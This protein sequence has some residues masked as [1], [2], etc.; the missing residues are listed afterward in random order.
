VHI[1]FCVHK[2]HYC[3]FNSHE[4]AKPD[5][6]AYQQ[7]LT[8]EL[9]CWTTKPA[10]AGRRL[11]TI[12]FGGGTPSLA[13]PSL[14][15]AV[16]DT[17]R[18]CC[19]IED[20]AEISLEANPG[21]VDSDNFRAYRQAGINRLSIGVQS[22]DANELHWLERIHGRD[23]AI[24]AY[25][26]AR[27][28]G[29][30]NINLDLMYGLPGQRL[31]DWLDTL[32]TAIELTPEHLSCYQLTVEPHTKLAAAHARKPYALP[33][34]D[35]ALSMFFETRKQLSAAGYQAYEISNFAKAEKKCRHNDG[36]W[37][38]HDYIG[39]GAGASGKWDH[40]G[41]HLRDKTDGG[42]TRYS[43]FRSPERYSETALAHGAAI[44]TQ[45]SLDRNQAAA[46]ACW[47]GLR[48]SDGINRQ[49]FHNRFNFDVWEH[50]QPKLQVWERN[51]KLVIHRDSIQLSASGIALADAISAS[52]L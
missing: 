33:D 45:E 10:F 34:D 46:E 2:C 42:I 9:K 17:A 25:R 24:S 35:I 12:F 40:S 48:R 49:A 41:D 7:A 32:H 1:P 29:F 37:L 11:D 52:V 14:I 36:Y 3:D 5:W 51:D 15:K 18:L 31:Q 21:T 22:L 8:T 39:I 19:G 43:N 26:I 27:D 16:I 23:E 50:F 20:D 4:R 44:N 47:L 38:Y 30:A 13:P 6:R 28:A